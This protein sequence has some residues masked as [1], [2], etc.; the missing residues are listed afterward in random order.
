M[1]ANYRM[2]TNKQ[3]WTPS[4]IWKHWFSPPKAKNLD[5]INK[6]VLITGGNAG[7]GKEVCKQLASMGC[8][9][10]TILARN[11]TTSEQTIFECQTLYEKFY[12]KNYTDQNKNEN[13]KMKVSI[14]E[15]L[16]QENFTFHQC[17]LGDQNNVKMVAIKLANDCIKKNRGF[18]VIICNAGVYPNI[19]KKT[20]DNFEWNFG[21][22]HLGHFA[23]VLTYLNTLIENNPNLDVQSSIRNE[24]FSVRMSEAGTGDT[25]K[26]VSFSNPSLFPSRI[27]SL[28]SI[29]HLWVTKGLNFD[30]LNWDDPSIQFDEK[31]AYGSGKMM[32]ILFSKSLSEKLRETQHLHGQKTLV[33]SVHPGVCYTG[34]FSE[35]GIGALAQKLLFRSAKNGAQT[36]LYAG[37]STNLKS[38]QRSGCYFDNCL[39]A[40][41]NLNKWAKMKEQRERL[42]KISSQTVKVDLFSRLLVDN[43]NADDESKDNET[44]DGYLKPKT[45][46][47]KTETMRTDLGL[48]NEGFEQADDMSLSE[49]IL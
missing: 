46:Y 37:F 14:N 39:P 36:I 27:V 38:S 6:K 49:T 9:D 16:G 4:A 7:L 10:I 45:V 8:S 30:N 44:D 12:R 15:N 43:D 41:Q 22:N 29:A 40:E 47:K 11:S 31:Y 34:L 35:Q 17:D 13:K 20:K 19:L 2:F 23:L 21:I 32:A 33:N 42:W 25:T 48:S 18:D 5:V 3:F 28:A 1:H 26:S 24:R